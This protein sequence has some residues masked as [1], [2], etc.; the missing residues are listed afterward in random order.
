MK[1]SNNLLESNPKD[2]K[3]LKLLRDLELS[4]EEI[5]AQHVSMKDLIN[6]FKEIDEFLVDQSQRNHSLKQS[7]V[8]K[9][10]DFMVLVIQTTYTNAFE[11]SR[12]YERLMDCLDAKR[13]DLATRIIYECILTKKEHFPIES[14]QTTTPFD[15]F[16][17]FADAL[18]QQIDACLVHPNNE[19]LKRPL[20]ALKDDL[21]DSANIACSKM[22]G[23]LQAI[24]AVVASYM[25][26]YRA[27]DALNVDPASDDFNRLLICYQGIFHLMNTYCMQNQTS[28]KRTALILSLSQKRERVEKSSNGYSPLFLGSLLGVSGA[29]AA[30][31]GA[32]KVNKESQELL[33]PVLMISSAILIGYH[34]FSGKKKTVSFKEEFGQ[35]DMQKNACHFIQTQKMAT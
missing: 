2:E 20:A 21:Q 15:S 14:N 18:I 33:A 8:S 17:L 30:F 27:C 3:G 9:K 7:I 19:E 25:H 16:A 12:D 29:A 22:T 5:M 10:I 35:N 11:F 6:K 32:K 34:F 4:A 23:Y 31:Y 1:S 26:L 24:D 28:E 13:R